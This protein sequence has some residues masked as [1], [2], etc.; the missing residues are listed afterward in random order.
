MTIQMEEDML[1]EVSDE[2]D[3]DL[4]EASVI[5]SSSFRQP[6]GPLTSF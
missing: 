2:D 5:L 4:L 6:F 3:R 1:T